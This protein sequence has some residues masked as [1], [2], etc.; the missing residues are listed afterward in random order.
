MEDFRQRSDVIQF[1]FE[2]IALATVWKMGWG[3]GW[4]DGEWRLEVN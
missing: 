3:W 2:K 1:M 4:E